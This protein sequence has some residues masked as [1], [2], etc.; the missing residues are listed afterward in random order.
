MEAPAKSVP[1][2]V[3]EVA[4]PAEVT[5]KFALALLLALLIVPLEAKP[6][7]DVILPPPEVLILLLVVIIPE[8]L[9]V[10]LPIRRAYL[11]VPVT[12]EGVGAQAI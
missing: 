6:D 7:E 11:F 2:V 10:P 12:P 1:A 4:S 8:L 5:K 9:N 3:L